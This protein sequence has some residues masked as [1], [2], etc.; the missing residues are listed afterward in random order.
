METVLFFWVVFG[1]A[2]L[3]AMAVLPRKKNKPN[4]E[5]LKNIAELKRMFGHRIIPH[6][7][8]TSAPGLATNWYAEL[9]LKS[10]LQ[11][12]SRDGSSE[13]DR[14]GN[15]ACS[16]V[17]LKDHTGKYWHVLLRA[18]SKSGNVNVVTT[19]LDELRA[20]RALF[21]DPVNYVKAFGEAPHRDQI[22][23]ITQRNQKDKLAQFD[24]NI[25]GGEIMAVKAIG[26]EFN[27]T[28][29]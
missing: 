26:Q 14:V 6:R 13:D 11:V 23:A 28:L 19:P 20:R 16:D 7:G 21:N 24:I 8:I 4:P 12:E 27:A 29:I 25:H 5:E 9:R 10:Q 1:L 22:K 17:V 15:T 3:V 2:I 18:N